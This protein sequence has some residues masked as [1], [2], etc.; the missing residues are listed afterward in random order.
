MLYE[1]PIY[2]T[3][4]SNLDAAL[5]A[6]GQ[7]RQPAI[8]QTELSMVTTYLGDSE[9]R[10]PM[11]APYRIPSLRRASRR[12][13]ML[14]VDG[15]MSGYRDLDGNPRKHRGGEYGGPSRISG[16]DDPM[17]TRTCR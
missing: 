2:L 17:N 5:A 10:C 13:K 3:R 15:G 12:L 6:K 14:A 11:Y 9:A 8:R 4:F 1:S 7:H 16:I